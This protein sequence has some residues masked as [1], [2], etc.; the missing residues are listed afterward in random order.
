[1]ASESNIERVLG[2]LAWWKG[3]LCDATTPETPYR[4]ALLV[5][6][7]ATLL[8]WHLTFPGATP[9]DQL[10]DPK[11]AQKA[12]ELAGTFAKTA[13]KCVKKT[14]WLTADNAEKPLSTLAVAMGALLKKFAKLY[15]HDFAPR[16]EL[17]FELAIKPA[18]LISRWLAENALQPTYRS[19][20]SPHERPA[21]G[22]IEEPHKYQACIE[23][24]LPAF[25]AQRLFDEGKLTAD[26]YTTIRRNCAETLEEA[27]RATM[28]AEKGR[29]QTRLRTLGRPV[30]E[31]LRRPVAPR[32]ASGGE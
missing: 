14:E 7:G 3:V 13:R 2:H 9:G 24:L 27:L 32:P 30:V 5:L 20:E 17:V 15:G 29:T 25:A 16:R 21:A 18:D 12:L 31:A 11:A 28:A 26:A 1:M 4:K 10:D 8:E 6:N 22:T 19:P 23:A